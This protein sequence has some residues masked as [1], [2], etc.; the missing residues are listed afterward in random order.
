MKKEIKTDKAP[1][2]SGLLSQGIADDGLI[3]T[4]GQIHQTPK[5]E[6]LKGTAEEITHQVMQNLKAI[7]EEGGVTFNDV[8]KATLYVTNMS[9]AK[10][11]NEVYVTY[12]KDPMPVREMV[13]VKELP[14]GASLEI[15]MIATKS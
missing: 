10:E 13:C 14:L 15:S 3:F 5:G 7:L 2:A 9:Q 1:I 12:F 4:S 8:L 6:L 11:I